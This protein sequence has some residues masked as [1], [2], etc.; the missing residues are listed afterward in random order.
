MGTYENLTA[1]CDGTI[2]VEK[3]E[4]FE[5]AMVEFEEFMKV[6]KQMFAPVSKKEQERRAAEDAMR[7][8]AVM[9]PSANA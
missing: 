9:E 7:V 2:T 3:L 4:R 8:G 6:A 1:C 5:L